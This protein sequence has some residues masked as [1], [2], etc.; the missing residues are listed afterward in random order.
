MIYLKKTALILDF[1][2]KV[3]FASY[4]N[5][6]IYI[7]DRYNGNVLLDKFDEEISF[8]DFYQTISKN[9]LQIFCLFLS[10][11]YLN[12]NDYLLT[13]EINKHRN[14]DEARLYT[15]LI[16]YKNEHKNEIVNHTVLMLENDYEIK[17][18]I[19]RIHQVRKKETFSL[20]DILM[21]Y[22]TCL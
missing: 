5:L 8:K 7:I 1:N 9:Y 13:K 20:N 22:I 6:D 16:N 18:I 15:Y 2:P 4:S 17:D 12:I 21:K 19:I 10:Y 3:D 11:D 14:A